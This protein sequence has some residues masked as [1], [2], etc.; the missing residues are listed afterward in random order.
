MTSR[1][2]TDKE[3]YARSREGGIVRL[4]LAAKTTNIAVLSMQNIASNHLVALQQCQLFRLKFC[5]VNRQIDFLSLI[6]SKRHD[7][8][9]NSLFSRAPCCKLATFSQSQ[10]DY[11]FDLGSTQFK[12]RVFRNFFREWKKIVCF[13]IATKQTKRLGTAA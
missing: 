6:V 11:N 3:V 10:I 8:G 4:S 1:R 5:R 9:R 2:R 12:R 13:P 7:I